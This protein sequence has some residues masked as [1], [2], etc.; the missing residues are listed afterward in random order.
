MNGYFPPQMQ[1]YITNIIFFS[2][3]VYKKHDTVFSYHFRVRILI[4]KTTLHITLI[5]V[6]NQAT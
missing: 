3:H 6:K 2:L 1:Q 5:Q 4:D